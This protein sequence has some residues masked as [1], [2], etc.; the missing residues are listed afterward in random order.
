MK[1]YIFPKLILLFFITLLVLLTIICAS[2]AS[3]PDVIDYTRPP[4]TDASL[5]TASGAAVSSSALS[6]QITNATTTKSPVTTKPSDQKSEIPLVIDL[7][8]P[9]LFDSS[10]N[11]F[12]CYFTDDYLYSFKNGDKCSLTIT[13]ANESAVTDGIVDLTVGKADFREEGIF[14]GVGFICDYNFTKGT[15]YTLD[16]KIESNQYIYIFTFSI[17]P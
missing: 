1:K 7:K 14:C 12:S 8:S 13:S 5:P 6:S 3:A 10:K 17:T 15:R 9:P 2:C 4:R 11:G 16:L